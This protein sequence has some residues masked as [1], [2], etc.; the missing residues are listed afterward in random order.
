MQIER[1]AVQARGFAPS[2][3]AVDRIRAELT[4]AETFESVRL[5]DVVT[6]PKRGGKGFSL[7]I[8][9]VDVE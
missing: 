2:F 5:S 1:Y 4:K 6:D 9:L 3:E 7:S 8:G